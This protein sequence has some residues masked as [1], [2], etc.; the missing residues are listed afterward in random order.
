MQEVFLRLLEQP[1]AFSGRSQLSTWLWRVTTNHCL[2]RLRDS[3]RRQKLWRKHH[4]DLWYAQRYTG[5]Q[6]HVTLLRELWLRLPEELAITGIFYH[7][8]GHT[9]AAIADMLGVSRRTVGHRLARLK[10]LALK[11]AEAGP[12]ERH[13]TS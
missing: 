5:G 7:L 8:D 10:A 12:S 1:E 2:N 9:H 6:D 3:K 11:D 13:A 4:R